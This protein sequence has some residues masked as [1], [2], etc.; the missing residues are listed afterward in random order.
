LES[1][2]IARGR[3][4]DAQAGRASMMERLIEER[5]AVIVVR[6][7]QIAGLDAQKS[8][9]E[10]LIAERDEQLEEL[11]RQKRS[12]EAL[13]VERDAQLDALNTQMRHAGQLIAERERIIVERDAQLA[14]ANERNAGLQQDAHRLE[15]EL[16]RSTARANELDTLSTARA[17][18]IE[19]LER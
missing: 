3:Q 18:R 5:E 17:Q 2:L 7:A 19:A 10:A 9:A 15:T 6:D 4:L 14:A 16:Q 1:L 12:A 11:D 8:R 13:M